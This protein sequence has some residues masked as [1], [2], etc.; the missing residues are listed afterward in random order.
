MLSKF[1][2]KDNNNNNNNTFVDCHSAVASE[3]QVE[4]VS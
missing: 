3:A 2:N 4:Q 1:N